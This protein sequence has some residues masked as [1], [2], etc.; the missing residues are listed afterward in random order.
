MFLNLS[1]KKQSVTKWGLLGPSKIRFDFW[2]IFINFLSCFK[3][4]GALSHIS[5]LQNLIEKAFTHARITWVEQA[6]LIILFA[7]K[8]LLIQF[9]S[10][11]SMFV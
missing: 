7:E 10:L 5:E 4:S 6:I 11:N 9:L 8:I 3:N 2:L 1:L